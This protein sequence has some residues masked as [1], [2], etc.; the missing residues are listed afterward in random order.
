M[1]SFTEIN[2]HY[3]LKY[4]GYLEDASLASLKTIKVESLQR[5]NESAKSQKGTMKKIAFLYR[6]TQVV[7]GTITVKMLST[8]P[9]YHLCL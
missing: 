1:S 7:K 3:I 8:K 9:F 6:V 4:F 2:R 5:M